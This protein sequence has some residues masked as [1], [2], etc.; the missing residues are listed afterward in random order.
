MIQN[1]V[2][3]DDTVPG[4]IRITFFN[5]QK[6]AIVHK[7]MLV[8]NEKSE[9]MTLAIQ[10]SQYGAEEQIRNLL[11]KYQNVKAFRSISYKPVEE[12]RQEQPPTPIPYTVSDL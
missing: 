6:N 8:G 12:F 5:P 10:Y 11:A 9:E 7:R 2:S 1:H 3:L 4:M